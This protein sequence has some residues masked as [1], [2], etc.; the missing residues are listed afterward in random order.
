MAALH[1]LT[2]ILN[3]GCGLAF[4]FSRPQ[5]HPRVV[6][7]LLGPP[8]AGKTTVSGPLSKDLGLVHIS[9]GN[10][11]RAE[12]AKG[13][14]QGMLFDAYNSRGELIPDQIAVD[15]LEAEMSKNPNKDF[16]LDGFPR[17]LEAAHIF[18]GDGE[19]ADIV[20]NL[21]VPFD[22]I[23]DR[24]S[25]RLIHPGSG[26]VY[27]AK[28]K[29]PKV[30]GKD[31]LTGEDLVRRKDDRPEVLERRLRV[32]ETKVVPVL[33]YYKEQGRLV[34]I[35][36]LD[37]DKVVNIIKTHINNLKDLRRAKFALPSLLHL[38]QIKN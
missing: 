23:R 30:E 18:E 4:T 20:F 14:E 17:T 27:N 31:D 22:V 13:T 34:N 8:G 19:A 2:L 33:E 37:S 9:V 3:L 36:E 29:P 35:K 10:L 32:F 21:D 26:R 7:V 15:L 1:L 12:I 28:F 11:I 5:I 6:V 25:N 38:L 24:I 16:L